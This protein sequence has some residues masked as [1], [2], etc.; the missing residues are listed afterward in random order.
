M[1]LA[2][3]FVLDVED[4]LYCD[5]VG[6]FDNFHSVIRYGFDS[7]FLWVFLGIKCFTLNLGL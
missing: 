4:E 5:F 7:D 3:D 1:I 6:L 2:G